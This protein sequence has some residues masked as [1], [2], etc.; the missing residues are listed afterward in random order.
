M[1]QAGDQQLRQQL[2]KHLEGGEAFTPVDDIIQ[3]IPFEKLGFVPESL[4][5]SFWQQFYHMRL[6]QYDILDFCRNPD[7]TAITWPDDYWPDEPTPKNQQE[8]D[9]TVKTYFTERDEMAKLISD[10]KNDLFAPL[11]H[12]SGQTLL[13]EALLVIEHTAYHTGQMLIILRLAGLY[14]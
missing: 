14:K 3:N 6:A 9:D 8:W 12:G 5:Y 1:E 4:P 13:R 10:S 2:V 11:P 7:Y